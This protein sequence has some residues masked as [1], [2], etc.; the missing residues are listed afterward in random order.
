MKRQFSGAIFAAAPCLIGSTA[1]Q[2]WPGPYT[3]ARKGAAVSVRIA[4][5]ACDLTIENVGDSLKVDDGLVDVNVRNARGS[6]T[7]KS[8]GSLG[9]YATDIRGSV[10]VQND[11]RGSIEVNNL[12]EDF[13]V[14][15]KG[16]D[17][18]Y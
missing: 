5:G 7:V 9:I 3:P 1:H 12:G 11:G 6:F 4:D 17:G 18:T 13:L 14:E 2:Q 15:S 16:S 8:G 10:I